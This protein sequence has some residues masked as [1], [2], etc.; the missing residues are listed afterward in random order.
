MHAKKRLSRY[1]AASE[2][3]ALLANG[4]CN[5]CSDLGA[6]ANYNRII[7]ES[8]S[9]ASSVDQANEVQ[10]LDGRTSASTVAESEEAKE[11]NRKECVLQQKGS[12]II[13]TEA[14]AS[15]DAKMGDTGAKQRESENLQRRPSST[16]RLIK[17]PSRIKPRKPKYPLTQAGHD[18]NIIQDNTIDPPRS[19]YIHWVSSEK[20]ED[21]C[22]SADDMDAWKS[23]SLSLGR[24]LCS[25][26]KRSAAAL[27][28]HNFHPSTSGRGTKSSDWNQGHTQQV[29]SLSTIWALTG[30]KRQTAWLTD[31]LSET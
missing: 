9:D 22:K 21:A 23:H 24:T 12:R 1:F 2:K 19:K 16:L 5:D 4:D 25:P 20:K 8:Q 28:R 17:Q 6:P 15:C 18:D 26:P 14:A 11:P 30:T 13:G 31:F 3:R 7:P 10:E 27:P 29:S